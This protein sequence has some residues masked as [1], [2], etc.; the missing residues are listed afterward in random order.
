MRMRMNGRRRSIE[1]PLYN[2][3]RV[4]FF[5]CYLRPIRRRERSYARPNLRCSIRLR[6]DATQRSGL[7][8]VSSLLF[9]RTFQFD[10]A[11]VT[12][13]RHRANSTLSQ[14]NDVISRRREELRDHGPPSNGEAG[15]RSSSLLLCSMINGKIW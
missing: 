2:A 10:V 5:A 7:P 9:I 15:N 8:V 14:E 4:D 11:I 6:R 13:H 12:S 1:I 3:V